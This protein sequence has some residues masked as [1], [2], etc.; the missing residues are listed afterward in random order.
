VGKEKKRNSFCAAGNTGGKGISD[1]V[2]NL[3]YFI[4]A[5]N[6]RW[7]AHNLF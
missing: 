6:W 2:L 1:P 5:A 7:F 3:K 4:Y